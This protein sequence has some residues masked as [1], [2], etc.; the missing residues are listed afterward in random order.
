MSASRFRPFIKAMKGKPD[1]MV[2]Q[3]KEK[4]H[5]HNPPNCP[6]ITQS[7]KRNCACCR[8]LRFIK[9]YK[10]GRVSINKNY[11]KKFYLTFWVMGVCYS[12]FVCKCVCV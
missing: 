1:Q 6:A 12:I 10:T 9:A 4:C 7:A 11:I 5:E 8:Y 3:L 2:A